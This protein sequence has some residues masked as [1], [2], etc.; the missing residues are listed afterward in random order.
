[1]SGSIAEAPLGTQKADKPSATLNSEPMIIGL[2]GINGSGKTS[3]LKNLRKVL[4][5]DEWVFYDSSQ[6]IAVF[7]SGGV[8]GFTSLSEYDKRLQRGLASERLKRECVKSGKDGV[9][10]GHYMSWDVGQATGNVVCTQQEL[11]AFTHILYLD[12]PVER[13]AEGDKGVPDRKRQIE[14][15][16]KWQEEERTRLRD[17]C[18]DSK[19]TFTVVPLPDKTVLTRI[20]ALRSATIPR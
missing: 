19:I 4:G 18:R 10:V 20:I 3:L 1:M 8:E 9:A 2:F 16:A 11:D 5:K 6:L 12:T 13:I 15:L 7:Y 14:H 17:R